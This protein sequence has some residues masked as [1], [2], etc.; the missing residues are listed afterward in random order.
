M[1]VARYLMCPSSFFGVSYVINPWMEHQIGQADSCRAQAQWDGLYRTFTEG[2]GVQVEL[3]EP[4]DGL[5]DMVFTANAGLIHGNTFVPARFAH[6]ERQGEEPYFIQW[7]ADQGF[8]VREIAGYQEG[9]GDMLSWTSPSG[10]STLVCAY[11]FRSDAETAERI[12]T[13]LPVNTL[14]VRLADPRFYHLDTCFCPLPGGHVLWFPE[15]FVPEA[16]A[17][18]RALIPESLRFEAA[19][20][21]AELFCC[22]AVGLTHEGQAHIVLGHVGDDARVWLEAKGFR[23]HVTPLS[24]FLKAGGSAKCLTLR[25]DSGLV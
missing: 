19:V 3:V 21:D 10:E 7:F 14:S 8:E 13:D 9:A 11:G 2:I 4:V 18:I 22:N 20:E 15:A 6:P 17:A 24:E 25:L 12:S 16:Q 5:P 1:K 23:V